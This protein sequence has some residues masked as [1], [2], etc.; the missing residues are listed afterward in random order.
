MEQFTVS[1]PPGLESGWNLYQYA[2]NPLSW[3]D[4]LGL[5]NLS[6][7]FKAMF[8]EAKRKLGI[9]KNTNTPQA[10][11]LFDSKYENRTVWEFNCNGD[12]KYIIIHENDIFC[13]DPHLH[14][15]DD[16]HEKPLEK[17]VCYNQHPG[18]IPENKTGITDM[19][20][21]KRCP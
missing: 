13:R 5:S 7:T 9:P 20:G 19:R 6:T 2:P 11:K 8:R 14:T 1:G 16:L 21:K 15:A 12:K 17:N 4:P 18:H 3:V 10:V